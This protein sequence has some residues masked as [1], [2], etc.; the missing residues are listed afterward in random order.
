MLLIFGILGTCEKISE[1]EIKDRKANMGAKLA[2]TAIAG[3][4]L[5]SITSLVIGIL[6]VFAFIHGMPPAAAY[7]LLGISGTVTLTWAS[8][9]LASKGESLE[10]SKDLIMAAF[11]KNY[12][13]E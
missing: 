3:D 11:S 9:A 6:G 4:A 10:H 12:S 8:L 5:I 13:Y 1:P 7:T 2:L